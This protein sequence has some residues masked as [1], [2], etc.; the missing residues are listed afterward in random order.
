MKCRSIRIDENINQSCHVILQERTLMTLWCYL[1]TQQCQQV[2]RTLIPAQHEA[3]CGLKPP[4]ATSMYPTASPTSTVSTEGLAF[5]LLLYSAVNN[6]LVEAQLQK[7]QQQ[8]SKLNI[9][10][11][12]TK[13]DILGRHLGLWETLINIFHHF[14]R[15]YR[16]ID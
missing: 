12:C 7:Q 2:Y 15:F 14:L 10:E 11:I 3:A 8:T 9:F 16:P 13:Q 6:S 5:T 1:E 4:T